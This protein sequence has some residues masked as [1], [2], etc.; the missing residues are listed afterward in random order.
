MM[1]AGDD[2]LLLEPQLVAIG[3]PAPT[4]AEACQLVLRAGRQP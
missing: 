3:V 1:A 2:R 4:A